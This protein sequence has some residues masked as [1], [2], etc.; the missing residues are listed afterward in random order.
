MRDARPDRGQATVEAVA[1]WLIIAVVA[2]LLLLG[3]PRL[4]NLVAGAL[5]GGSRRAAVRQPA[6]AALA[7][8]ALA[9]RGGRG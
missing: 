8:R 9:G 5:D 4:D 6:A 3:L 1:L 2:G 7:E